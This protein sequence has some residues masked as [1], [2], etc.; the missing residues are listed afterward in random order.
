M[1]EINIKWVNLAI[2]RK[3]IANKALLIAFNIIIT[4][5]IIAI[6]SL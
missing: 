5:V 6:Y 1:L 4:R 2:L 3:I